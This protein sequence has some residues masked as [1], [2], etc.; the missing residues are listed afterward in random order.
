ML[1]KLL[2]KSCL[3]QQKEKIFSLSPELFSCLK[4]IINIENFIKTSA[5]NIRLFAGL[6]SVL[7]SDPKCILYRTKI[8]WLSPENM[9][10][11]V[12]EMRDELLVFRKENDSDLASGEFILLLA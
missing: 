5:R 11:R 12:F 6:C 1:R 10:R 2:E 9:T 7:G 4:G 8:R 3:I